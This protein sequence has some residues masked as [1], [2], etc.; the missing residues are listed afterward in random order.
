MVQSLW[1]S[2]QAS[3]QKST[4]EQ[5]V[6]RSNLIGTDRSVCN[7]GGGN[8]SAK[9]TIQ[10]FRGRE[11]EVMYVKGSG[12]D[13]ATMKAH[14]FTGLRMED[15]RPLFEREEMSDEV[16][17]AYLANCMIDA[18]HPRASIEALLHAFLPFKHV[19]H[20]HPDAII[21]LC[22]A[23]NG[24]EIAKEIFGN[25]F[26]W[27]PYIR[28]GFKLSKMIAQGVLDHPQAELV[29][30]EKHGLVTWG[31]TS[32]AAY[33]KT[34]EIIQEAESYIK[35]R[36]AEKQAFGGAKYKALTS[37]ERRSIVSQVMPP[38]R[39]QSVMRKDDPHV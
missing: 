2:S 5:L 24:K 10:D 28:P 34:I 39:G 27:V 9:T 14:N 17:I 8:T 18:K 13:L 29:L 30:M 11:V 15:I 26:V 12:S 33:A 31:D 7:W 37:E 20:T 4:L 19:D 21:S 32:E 38:V 3:E 25:R 35:A 16:M 36:Q 23:H 1:N 22:C 6:Y